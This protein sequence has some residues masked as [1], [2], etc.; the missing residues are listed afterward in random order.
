MFVRRRLLRVLPFRGG[1]GSIGRR[2]IARGHY[3]HLWR[4]FDRR[5]GSYK[6]ERGIEGTTS[7]SARGPYQRLLG[8]VFCLGTE[9]VE[10]G[11]KVRQSGLGS[12]M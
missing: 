12:K 11:S 2:P 3:W 9:V 8:A 4:G 1:Q 5:T 7:T 6:N 10:N